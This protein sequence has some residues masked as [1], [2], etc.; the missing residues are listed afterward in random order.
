MAAPERGCPGRA[1][2]A[3]LAPEAIQAEFLGQEGATWRARA[4]DLS[5]LTPE[6]TLLTPSSPP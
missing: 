3:A 4:F 5:L 1:Q 6:V 2:P